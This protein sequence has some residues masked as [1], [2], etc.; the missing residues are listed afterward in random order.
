MEDDKKMMKLRRVT[1]RR[2]TAPKTGTYTFC[3][4]SQAKGASTLQRSYF[5]IRKFEKHDGGPDGAQNLG[6]HFVRVCAGEM[7]RKRHFRR[8]F[9]GNMPRPGVSALIKHRP[10]HLPYGHI[11]WDTR[12][13]L[14]E[15]ISKHNLKNINCF[16]VPR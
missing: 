15:H 10:C 14:S 13:N 9:E 1:L 8:K 3:E 2:K 7:H 5:I 16:R 11:V 6:P 12:H 4:P